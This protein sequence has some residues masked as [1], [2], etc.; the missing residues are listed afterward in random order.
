[1]RE[2]NRTQGLPLSS[3]VSL[4]K[5]VLPIK[6]HPGS[7]YDTDPPRMEPPLLPSYLSRIRGGAGPSHTPTLGQ[8]ASGGGSLMTDAKPGPASRGVTQASRSQTGSYLR[9]T[10]GHVWETSWV[11]EVGPLSHPWNPTVSRPYVHKFIQNTSWLSLACGVVSQALAASQTR[12]ST[13]RKAGVEWVKK[14]IF[15]GE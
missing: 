2:L 3:S 12:C 14:L 13:R 8:S 7:T 1:M 5:E 6:E 11:Y 10:G 9:Q 4:Q 15:Y